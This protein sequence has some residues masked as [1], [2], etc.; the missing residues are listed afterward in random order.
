MNRGRESVQ[1]QATAMATLKHLCIMAKRSSVVRL[2]FG[3]VIMMSSSTLASSIRG[4]SE[5]SLGV[6]SAAHSMPITYHLVVWSAFNKHY[7]L[8]SVYS[9]FACATAAD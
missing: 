7:I 5:L 2:L 8:L 4:E 3:E 1:I 6:E 9:L